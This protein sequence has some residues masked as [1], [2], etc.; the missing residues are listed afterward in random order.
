MA[1][2]RWITA[3]GNIGT[4]PSLVPMSFQFFAYAFPPADEVSYSIVNGNLPTGLSLNASGKLSGIP[5]LSLIKVTYQIVVRVTDNDGNYDDRTFN[6]VVTPAITLQFVT[7]E[8]LI[9]NYPAQIP[10]SFQIQAV[11]ILFLTTIDYSIISGSLPP[12]LTMNSD[13]LITGT[14][15]L[16]PD[17]TEFEFVVRIKGD[18]DQFRDRTFKIGVSNSL[19]PVFLTSPGSI[20]NTVDSVWVEIPIQY[21]NPVNEEILIRKIQGELPPGLEIND[22][23]LI[24]GYPKPPKVD[25]N[26]GQEVTSISATVSTDNTITALSTDGFVVGRQ[27]RFT[28]TP[29]G[30]LIEYIPTSSNPKVYY[31]HSIIDEFKFKITNAPGEEAI[32]LNNDVGYMIATLP[33]VS[34][35]QPTLITYS[36]TLKIENS[37]GSNLQSYSITVINQN[38]PR[39]LGGPGKSA[40]TRLP[41][42]LNTRPLTY[43]IEDNINYYGYYVFPDKVNGVTYLPQNKAY[44]GEIQSDDLFLFQIIGYDFDGN[45]LTYIFSGL[46]AELEGDPVTG[47]VTGNIV[48]PDNTIMEYSFSVKV[49]KTGRPDLSSQVFNFS[50]KIYNDI[51]GKILWLTPNDLGLI[52]NGTVCV[53]KVVAVSDVPLLY[54]IKSGSLPPNLSLLSNGEITG[55]TAYQP[56]SVFLSSNEQS[57][58]TFEIEAYNQQFDIIVSSKTFT[59]TV[60]QEYTQPTDTLYIRCT[61]DI[62]DRRLIESLLLNEELIPYNYLYRPE[63]PNFGKAKNVT[64][65][66]AYGIH[67]SDFEEYIAAVTENHYW[68]NI[69]LGELSTAVARNEN[70]DIVY[71]VVYSN[72]IDNLVNLK[73]PPQSVSKQIYWPYK[74]D[75]NKGPWYTSVTNVYTSYI[76]YQGEFTFYTSLTPGYA[77]IFYPNSLPNMRKQVAD[78]LGQNLDFDLL[79]NWMT[80]Q[81]L[82]GSTLGYI[83]A[84]VICYTKPGYSEIIKNNIQTNWKNEL[85]QIN[86]LN[87]INLQFDRFT[88]DK[89]ITYNYDKNL[90]P[91]AWTALP[92]ATPTPDPAD[93]KNFYVLFPTETIL[94]KNSQY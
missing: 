83:P 92:S 80:S 2:P 57:T 7:P 32:L 11:S 22:N 89:S 88:V 49:E 35:G 53:K 48:I 3:P 23:G 26:L 8:G 71:E 85:G 82:N 61:P 24:R 68:K 55:T 1:E 17:Q 38:L 64:Y 94:P 81:Q 77:R 30:G 6:F 9:A 43:N 42:I 14:P 5:A 37:R 66:H 79:P 52:Y 58:F 39:P 28:G 29:F 50:F 36:F 27:I 21:F 13:G 25:V 10:V 87:L 60:L 76:S 78:V 34:V 56:T 73:T 19:L 62:K 31:I 84:W 45:S 59:L 90:D 41:T 51:K 46:P 67:A 72:V 70:G 65:A 63:D 47:W 15:D 69:V 16:S 74:V 40:N 12:G 20:L 86:T 4:Y 91:P 54:R 33:N 75:L 18:I 93:S 44:I